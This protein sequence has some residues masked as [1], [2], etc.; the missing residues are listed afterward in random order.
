MHRPPSIRTLPLRA[1]LV[2]AVA[3]AAVLCSGCSRNLNYR[4]LHQEKAYTLTNMQPDEARNRLYSVN[5]QRDG[6]IPICTPVKIQRVTKKA[7]I[8]TRLDTNQQYYYYFHHNSMRDP[9]PVHLDKYFGETC[10][11]AEIDALSPTDLAGVQNAEIYQGMSKRGVVLAVGY[12]P[13][14]E[15]PRLEAD[16]WKYWDT[17]VSTF[18]VHFEG[19]YVVGLRE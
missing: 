18:E 7:M 6:L 8:F 1:L 10:P 16:V 12:P 13:E 17:K 19:G 9:I 14:H 4:L 5:Y 2:A 3:L 11:Q 15:T